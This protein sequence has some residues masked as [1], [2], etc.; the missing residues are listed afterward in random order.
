M[1]MILRLLFR[2][3]LT[4]LAVSSAA[5][6]AQAQYT[7]N[8][9]FDTVKANPGDTAVDVDVYYKF[10]SIPT[11]AIEDFDVRFEYDTTEIYAFDYI[12]DGTASANMSILDTS[13]HGILVANG[14]LDLTNPILFKIRFRVNQRLA[15]TSFIQWDTG[16]TVFDF[17]DS[18]NLIEQNGWIK[19]PTA[20]GHVSLSI[21]SKTVDTGEVFTIPVSITGIDSANIDSGVLRFEVDTTILPFRGAFASALSNS[22]VQS[23]NASG[24]TVS[25]VLK[26]VNGYILSSDS[27]VTLSF[28]SIPWFDTACVTLQDI[29]FEAL[30]SGSLIGNTISSNGSICIIP[31]SKPSS[32]VNPATVRPSKFVAYPNPARDQVTFDAGLGGNAGLMTIDVYDALGRRAYTSSDAYPVWQIPASI[33]PGTYFVIMNVRAGRFTTCLVIEP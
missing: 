15:D 22:A 12:L 4:A 33:Q 20:A 1:A 13:H 32:G 24:D 5:V 10:S 29:R 23:S 25:I 31:G 17:A 18:I 19:T 27:L 9:R 11:E 3:V 30:N 14:S 7:V 16:V 8:L 26:A 6:T 28:Y 2:V 21:P